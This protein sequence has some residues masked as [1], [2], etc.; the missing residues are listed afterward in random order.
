MRTGW[1]Q[2]FCKDR[3]TNP[4]KRVGHS[5]HSGVKSFYGE[6]DGEEFPTQD[7][8]FGFDQ[9]MNFILRHGDDALEALQQM[10][11]KGDDAD[12]N[13]MIEQM[14]KDGMLEKDGNGKLRLTPRAVTSMQQKALMEVFANMTRGQREGHEKVTVGTGG[15]RIDGTKVYQYGDPVSELDLHQTMHNALQRHGLPQKTSGGP[16]RVR[17][18]ENDLELHL[19][20]GVTSCSTVVLLDMSGSMMRYGR[21]LSAKKVAM[22]DAGPGAGAVPAGHD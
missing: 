20:E 10:M 9:L 14:L 4:L 16:G 13:E 1:L 15:E 2:S 5:Y 17:F 6:Y 19:H 11:D 8:L 12:I 3:R 18:D 21:W 7:K 22:G